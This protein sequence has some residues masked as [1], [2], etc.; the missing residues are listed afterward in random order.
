MEEKVQIDPEWRMLILK[1]RLLGLTK[2]EVRRFINGAD[3]AHDYYK[4]QQ[5]RKVKQK[6]DKIKENHPQQ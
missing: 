5:T 1:A 3:T 6:K 4:K 2:D